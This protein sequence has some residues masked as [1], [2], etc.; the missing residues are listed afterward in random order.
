MAASR[1]SNLRLFSAEAVRMA[2]KCRGAY[3]LAN[4]VRFQNFLR[5]R[6]NEKFLRQ[7]EEFI[8]NHENENF[9]NKG[10][11]EDPT[12]GMQ[13]QKFGG[14]Q[15]YEVSVYAAVGTAKQRSKGDDCSKGSHE[16]N[17]YR[18]ERCNYCVTDS[19]YIKS[20]ST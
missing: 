17:A 6:F 13:R 9:R 1:L 19:T 16:C 4:F 5:V 2:S 14:G 20:L 18:F 3:R 11:G 10:Q 12:G 7:Q 15:A 8:Q